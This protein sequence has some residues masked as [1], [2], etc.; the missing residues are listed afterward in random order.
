V[1]RRKDKN[2]SIRKS[3]LFAVMLAFPLATW[4]GPKW[5]DSTLVK[6]ETINGWCQHCGSDFVKTNY[7]FKL[8]DGT[9]YVGQIGAG[10]VLHH[11]NP[12][13]VTL[14]GHIQFRFEKEGHVGDYIHILDDSGKDDKLQIIGKTASAP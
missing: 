11:R 9:V 13:D 6:I 2:M 10:G 3:L 12:L 1:D 5:Q 8:D 14:N 7:S 4:A